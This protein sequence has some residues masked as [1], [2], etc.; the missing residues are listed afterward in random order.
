MQLKSCAIEHIEACAS[1]LVQVY[2]EPEYGGKWKISDAC[3]Y[4]KR[5]FSIEPIGCFVAIKN[6]EVV[7]AIFSYS[8]PWQA[9]TVV[10]IQELFIS[11]NNRSMGVAKLLLNS[12]GNGKPVKAWLIANDN[13]RAYRISSNRP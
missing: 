6:K 13:T 10:Y 8:Y 12:V 7:A 3:N 4:L 1:L 5:F 11:I 2:S 9:E